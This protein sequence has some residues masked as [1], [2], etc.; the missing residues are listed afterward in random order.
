[1]LRPYQVRSKS[2]SQIAKILGTTHQEL[3]P[4][5]TGI[6]QDSQSVIVGD[7]FL[8][9]PGLRTHGAKHVTDATVR[10]A[11]AML[12]DSEGSKYPSTIPTIIVQDVRKAAGILSAWFYGEPM[13]DMFSVGITG[14]NGKTTTTT[15]LH[16]IWQKAGRKSGLIGTINTLI[17]DEIFPNKRTTPESSELQ[18][19]V[20]LMREKNIKNLAMEVSSHA[21]ALERVRGAHYSLLA[22]SNLSQDHLDFHHSI[23]EYF[24]VKARIFSFEFAER[25][26]INMDDSY[27]PREKSLNCKKWLVCIIFVSHGL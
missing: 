8:G 18:A 6:T 7:I 14:T 19:I 26:L 22:F 10:G 24:A 13:R 1:M 12:T 23:E 2:L 25:A 11:R 15:L 16:Q 3:N 5:I 9:L 4:S 17:N 20:A 21:I 27:G